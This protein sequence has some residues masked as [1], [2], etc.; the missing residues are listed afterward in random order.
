MAPELARF[1]SGCSISVRES[2]AGMHQ[3]G[4]EH[5]DEQ[6]AEQDDPTR[7]HG[8]PVIICVGKPRLRQDGAPP[9]PTPGNHCTQV[10]KTSPWLLDAN[11][12]PEI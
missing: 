12:L 2:D 4:E 11:Q 8:T 5:L 6:A 10:F 1:A 9:P 7:L 3:H